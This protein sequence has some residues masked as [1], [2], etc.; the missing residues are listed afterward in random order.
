[1]YFFVLAL[2][3]NEN[4]KLASSLALNLKYGHHKTLKN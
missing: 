3:L 4:P 1:M 2:L